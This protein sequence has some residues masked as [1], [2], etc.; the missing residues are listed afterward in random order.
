MK[1][2]G[3]I[4]IVLGA[5]TGAIGVVFHYKDKKGYEEYFGFAGFFIILGILFS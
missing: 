4:F 5:I 1:P 2:L 3:I